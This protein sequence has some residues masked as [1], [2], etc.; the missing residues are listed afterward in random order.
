MGAFDEDPDVGKQPKIAFEAAS[1][2]EPGSSD[3]REV[4][5]GRPGDFS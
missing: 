2:A 3:Q 1:I 4:S 5:T